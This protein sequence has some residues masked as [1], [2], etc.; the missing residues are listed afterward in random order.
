MTHWV[1]FAGD[2]GPGFGRLASGADPAGGTGPVDV[3]EG[4]MYA[5]CAPTGTTVDLAEVE[6]LSPC[7]PTK[8]IGIWNNFH[9]AAA[10][11][12]WSTPQHPLYF[13]KAPSCFLAP[14]GT[15]VPP[16]ASEG[17]VV[18][19]AELGV[20]IGAECANVSEDEARDAIFGYTCVNDVTAPRVLTS[21]ESFPQ[22]C[23]A[24][25]FDTFG[26]FG[27]AILAAD[28]VDPSGWQVKTILNGRVRQDYPVSDMVFA[29]HQLV[30]LISHDMTLV[31]G[32]VISCG[33]SL[34]AGPMRDGATVE[35]V[36]NEVGTLRNTFAAAD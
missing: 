1:R 36:I 6:L 29:P 16:P 22:W 11:N 7:Q 23:R 24:K 30:S 21:D 34:G 17:R 14:G 3:H 13:F 5:G 31:P 12:G 27:P 4:D 20:V 33:T 32:D 28:G 19:E 18:Y 15:I 25:S 26:P 35:I 10:K 8:M 2:D 9:A